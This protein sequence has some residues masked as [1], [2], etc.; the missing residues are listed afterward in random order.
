MPLLYL[1]LSLYWYVHRFVNMPAS[2]FCSSALVYPSRPQINVKS[3]VNVNGGIAFT[4]HYFYISLCGDHPG[5]Y[6]VNILAYGSLPISMP[7][8]TDNTKDQTTVRRRTITGNVFYRCTA[9]PFS[10]RMPMN[11][12]NT[13]T[14]QWLPIEVGRVCQRD[15]WC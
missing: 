9:I 6:G 14:K 5:L 12:D 1:C 3:T 11:N 7:T 13:Q 10:D 4:F 2:V 15:L 8:N